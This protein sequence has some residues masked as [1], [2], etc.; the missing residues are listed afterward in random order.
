MSVGSLLVASVSDVVP[1]AVTSCGCCVPFSS[2][3]C[4]ST[5]VNEE[6]G[7]ESRLFTLEETDT[8]VVVVVVGAT[9]LEGKRTLERCGRWW[10]DRGRVK[11]SEPV[12]Q[13]Q[14][15]IKTTTIRAPA[16]V[17]I[18]EE[19]GYDDDT[20]T[21]TRLPIVLFRRERVSW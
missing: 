16:I 3:G 10:K 6:E 15:T 20:V 8:A 1:I 12:T 4:G 17:P 11:A 18:E 13:R 7:E 2:D 21:A 5:D 14:H 9:N 19:E